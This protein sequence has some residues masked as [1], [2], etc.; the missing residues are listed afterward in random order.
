MTDKAPERHYAPDGDTYEPV[1]AT[2]STPTHPSR[3]LQGE[4]TQV[5]KAIGSAGKRRGP[6]FTS[7]SAREALAVRRQKEAERKAQ[8]E[9]DAR[10][11]HLTGRQRIGLGLSKVSQED[12]DLVITSLVNQA[13]AGDVK[14][15]HALARLFDQGFGRAGAEEAIDPKP[16]SERP[17]EQWTEAER[18]EWRAT[19]LAERARQR[20]AAGLTTDPRTEQ[21]PDTVSL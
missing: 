16:R 4:G 2:E 17:Y 12:I 21:P 18:S 20:E 9:E 13:K 11:T 5:G 7:E 19:L 1:E 6:G 10:L 3:L 15:I 8:R 14:S